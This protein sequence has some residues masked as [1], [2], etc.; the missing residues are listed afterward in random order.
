MAKKKVSQRV[1]RNRAGG[2][3][4]ESQYWLFI[5]NALRTASYTKYP[6]IVRQA[7]D[8][9]KRP[10]QSA[11]K[12]L[13]WEYQCAA[14]QLWYARKLVRV[15]H[16]YPVGSFLCYDD[17]PAYIAR[18]FCEP[19]DLRILCVDCDLDRGWEDEYG[20]ESDD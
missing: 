20:E 7:L 15:D 10:S 14:C 11:N 17:A 19:E 18:L 4:T 2:E 8:R 9:V 5:R 13:R 1:P 16:I 6:P 12:R 3:F